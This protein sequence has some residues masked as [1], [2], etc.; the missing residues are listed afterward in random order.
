M[1]SI[2]LFAI[3]LD[4]HFCLA[5]GN[6]L[7]HLWERADHEDGSVSFCVVGTEIESENYYLKV[8]VDMPP[9]GEPIR[10]RLPHSSV[11]AILDLASRNT[12]P[13]FLPQEESHE[14]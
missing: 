4:P 14:Q 9:N 6:R 10:V 13:G 1:R 3:I 7:A 2:D 5:H 12:P 11:V 8:L